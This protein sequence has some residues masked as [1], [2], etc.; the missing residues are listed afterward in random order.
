MLGTLFSFTLSG[1]TTV[2]STQPVGE[3]PMVLVA[4]EWEGTRSDTEDFLEMRVID[5]EGG[6]LEAA[7]IEG[8]ED[9]FELERIEVVVRRSGDAIF[10]NALEEADAEDEPGGKAEAETLYAF[11]RLARDGEKLVIWWPE[12]DAFREL[13][14]SGT[15]PG[16]V[17]EGK[18]VVLET[19]SAEQLAL[20][21]SNE[22]AYL[23]GW[24]EPGVLFRPGRP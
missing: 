16:R 21:S 4:E 22:S 5:A 23:Y 15:L 12:A 6:R 17:T 3:T 10:G 20:L 19:L 11:F 14:E 7:W 9:G 18:D 13:V 8:R 2:M 24:K 1:C